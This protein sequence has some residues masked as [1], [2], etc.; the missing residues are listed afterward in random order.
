VHTYYQ[1]RNGNKNKKQKGRKIMGFKHTQGSISSH[2]KTYPSVTVAQKVE[3]AV[4]V[5]STQEAIAATEAAEIL[6]SFNHED[7]ITGNIIGD[8]LVDALGNLGNGV[9]D[10]LGNLSGYLY[11]SVFGSNT[12]E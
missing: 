4:Q 3:A 9:T 10:A 5:I 1:A 6:A 2:G 11:N 7:S 12:A 8:G